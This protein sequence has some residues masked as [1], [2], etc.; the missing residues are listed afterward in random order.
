MTQESIRALVARAE[1]LEVRRVLCSGT[2]AC[3]SRRL[4]GGKVRFIVLHYPG[5]VISPLGL[6]ERFARENINGNDRKSSAHFVID[7]EKKCVYSAV[8]ENRAAWHVGDGQPSERYTALG[9]YH[10]AV[11][12]HAKLKAAGIADFK[13][14]RESIG[15]EISCKRWGGT[16]HGPVTDQNWYFDPA[17]V[18]LALVLCVKLCR[19]YG[20]TADAVIRHYDA[21]G[22]PCPRPFVTLPC[23][24]D[25]T[26]ERAWQ[27]FKARLSDALDAGETQA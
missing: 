23:D 7:P 14:N 10:H 27:D 24:P 16:K 12:W 17:A 9:G 15:V 13:G 26:N 11:D 8:P 20:L 18:E 4:C 25:D 21:T 19:Q 5:V 2:P 6:A 1:R 22:K 3:S